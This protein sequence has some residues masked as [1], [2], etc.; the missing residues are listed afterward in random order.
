MNLCI[1]RLSWLVKP[2]LRFIDFGWGL[3]QAVKNF[4]EKLKQLRLAKRM[5]QSEVGDVVGVTRSAVQQWEN[6]STVP[7]LEKLVELARFFNITLAELTGADP[8]DK[9][10]DQEL[11]ELPAD[12]QMILRASFLET[13]KQFKPR[14]KT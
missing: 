11:R 10:I 1:E 2:D 6:G 8:V 4:P 13:I 14:Q 7:A 5:S 12:T 3:K 9:S